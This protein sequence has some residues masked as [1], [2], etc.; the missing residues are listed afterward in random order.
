MRLYKHN[1]RGFLQAVNLEI[2]DLTI[3]SY[4][5]I[6]MD[7]TPYI[8]TVYCVEEKSKV[9]AQWQTVIPKSVREL[10]KISIGDEIKWRYESGRIIVVPPDRILNPSEVLYGLIPSG[11]NA[12][13]EVRKVRE[14]GLK[15]T[16]P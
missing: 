9:M 16:L 10:A 14:E 11:S 5:K 4:V 7:L 2:S 6:Y 3:S 1:L 15:R 8:H 13:K 12:V